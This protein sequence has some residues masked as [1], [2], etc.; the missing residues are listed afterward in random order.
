MRV[1]GDKGRED[2]AAER[3]GDDERDVEKEDDEEDDD[4]DMSCE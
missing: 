4:D 3:E 1:D 2:V